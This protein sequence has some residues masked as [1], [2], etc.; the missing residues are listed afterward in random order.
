MQ[1]GVRILAHSVAPCGAE[2]ITWESVHPRPVHSEH[3]THRELSR[4]SG[5][6]RAIPTDK[7]ITTVVD[8]PF[9]PSYIG[10]NQRGMQ[11]GSALPAD[12]RRECEQTWLDARD[13]MVDAARKMSRLGAHKQ[14]VNRL[15][16]PFMFIK[17]IFTGMMPLSNLLG[18]RDHEAAE[19][20]FQESARLLK[21]A[22][23]ASSPRVLAAGEW[24][25]P[26]VHDED[27][28]LAEAL[29][30]ERNETAQDVLKKVSVGRCARASYHTHDGRRD[31]K[32][33][34]DLHDRLVV[35]QPLHASPAEHV[36]QAMD[37]PR[38]WREDGHIRTNVVGSMGLVDR[39]LDECQRYYHEH[40][41][42]LDDD[43][44]GY[45]H[46]CRLNELGQLALMLRQ[47]QSGNIRGFRQ[48]RKT[49]KNEYIGVPM[50]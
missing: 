49:F 13:L 44:V 19:P 2:I 32:E 15:V 43:G 46:P 4:S 47:M 16:E 48:Y 27:L 22:V 14:V 24:H 11:A 31:L 42:E 3:L 12:V 33:D 45:V 21:A 20:H 1:I 25:M 6:S 50:P 5:S 7:L 9:V 29:A 38:W 34:I 17:V 23:A 30:K 35:Q 37:F 28:S 8:D 36:A 10:A 41:H 18:L 40:V 39:T 26:L